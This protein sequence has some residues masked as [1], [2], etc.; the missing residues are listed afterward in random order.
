MLLVTI[1]PVVVVPLRAELVPPPVT[2]LEPALRIFVPL[3]LGGEE[4]V[5]SGKG[6]KFGS[7]HG[8]RLGLS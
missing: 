3:V 2:L 6:V 7:L 5:E 4:I 8:E 1:P